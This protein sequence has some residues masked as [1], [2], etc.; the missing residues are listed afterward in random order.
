[1]DRLSISPPA[2]PRRI[3]LLG[4]GLEDGA[5]APVPIDDADESEVAVAGAPE[6]ALETLEPAVVFKEVVEVV[7]DAPGPDVER[8]V[9]AEADELPDTLAEV[10]E[11][12]ADKV[13]GRLK[14]AVVTG[15]VDTESED[16]AAPVPL[17]SLGFLIVKIPP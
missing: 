6:I 16:G 3:A 13:E 14:L 12:E 7:D 17:G 9:M 15:R 10:A 5:L 1:M 8:S 2:S 11:A 4:V